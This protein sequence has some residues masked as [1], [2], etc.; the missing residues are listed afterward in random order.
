MAEKKC[1]PLQGCKFSRFWCETHAF[2]S[3]L[4]LAQKKMSLHFNASHAQ[5][6]ACFGQSSSISP[7]SHAK[8]GLE[9]WPLCHCIASTLLALGHRVVL[10]LHHPD[11]N[12]LGM[13]KIREGPVWGCGGFQRLPGALISGR[14][15]LGWFTCIYQF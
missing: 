8:F 1:C 7:D 11:C 10:L 15:L 6:Y 4:T 3:C 2:L 12:I 13:L 14:A 9:R 5:K